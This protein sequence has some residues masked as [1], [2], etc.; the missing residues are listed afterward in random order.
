MNISYQ[1]MWKLCVEINLKKQKW[2]VIAIYH[3]NVDGNYFFDTLSR[4]IDLYSSKYDRLVAMGDCNLEPLT[5]QIE[6]L[7][8]SSNLNKLVKESTCF[9]SVP[10]CYDLILTNQKYSILIL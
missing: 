10:K 7:C 6:A 5:E 2:F 8:N 3:P 4:T 9:K 1:V